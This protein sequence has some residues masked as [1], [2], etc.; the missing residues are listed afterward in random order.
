MKINAPVLGFLLCL[1]CLAQAAP[2]PSFDAASIRPIDMTQHF[3]PGFQTNPGTLNARAE[4]LQDCIQWAY[5]LPPF[6]VTGPDWL[7]MSRF[8]IVAK[9]AGPANEDQLRLMLRT[10]LA[11][12]F[13]VKVHSEKKEMQI[14]LLT[15]AKGGPKFKESTTEGPPVFNRGGRG[16]M[17][18]QR[19]SMKDVAQQI[20]E[21]LSRPVIDATGLTGR[22]DIQIDISSYMVSAAAAGK[23]DGELDVMSILFTGLQEQLGVRLEP[24]KD[25]VEILVVDHAEKTPLEN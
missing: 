15:L 23:G 1:R 22:Y 21:P 19:V 16:S 3:V 14:Y 5:D 18:A 24:K 20:S 10:L 17:T 13:G 12:R 25:T 7:R 4:T 6:E 11:D 9:A 8:D 2:S